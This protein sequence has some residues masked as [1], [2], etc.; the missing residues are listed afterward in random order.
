M[1]TANREGGRRE[2][3]RMILVRRGELGLTQQQAADL[4]GIHVD[5]LSDVETGKTWFRSRNL[6]AVARAL[7]LDAAELQRLADEPA[8]AAS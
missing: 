5:T 7:G 1:T 6:A 8:R 3:A 2:A 4:A